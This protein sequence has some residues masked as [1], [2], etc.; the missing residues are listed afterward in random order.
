MMKELRIGGYLIIE[1]LIL[2]E[3]FIA[4]VEEDLLDECL[5]IIHIFFYKSIYK[6]NV[7]LDIIKLIF[8]NN[9]NSK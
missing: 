7:L 2:G 5:V 9:Y 8:A 6:E 1:E 3:I 4:E